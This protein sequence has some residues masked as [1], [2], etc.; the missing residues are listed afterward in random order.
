MVMILNHSQGV[1]NAQSVEF[2]TAD[3]QKIAQQY[4]GNAANWPIVLE[5]SRHDVD[6]NVLVLTEEN[7]LRLKNFSA[8]AINFQKHQK[9]VSELLKQGAEL[10][11]KKPLSKANNQIKDYKQAVKQGNYKLAAAKAQQLGESMPE[12]ETILN[13]NRRVAIQAE[14]SD[15]EGDVDKRKGL[16]GSWE[17]AQIGDYFAQSDG[18]K[19][20]ENSLA[21]L[22]FV[23]GSQIEIE[24]STV[25]V[26]RESR[27]DKLTESV[28]TDIILEDGGVLAKLSASAKN[29][30]NYNLEAGDAQT[31][32][33]STNFYA[34]SSNSQEVK[35]SNYDGEA[36]VEANDVTVTIRKNEGTV[37]QKGGQPAEP[38]KLLDAPKPVSTNTDTVIFDDSF[39]LAFTEIDEA[40][41]YR[42]EVST[43]SQFTN[44]LTVYQTTSNNLLVENLNMGTNYIHIQSID[45]FGLRGPFSKTYRV[46]RN[47]DNQPP[48]I[49]FSNIENNLIYTND[50]QVTINGVTEPEVDLSINGT[51]VP[52]EV[53]GSFSVDVSLSESE[54]EVSLKATDDSGNS[55]TKNVHIV[56]IDTGY[57]SSIEFNAT[58]ENNTITLKQDILQFSGMAYPK[59]KIMV[60]NGEIEKTIPTD[61]NGRWGGSMKPMKPQAGTLVF[62][63]IDASNNNVLFT[64][65][66]NVEIPN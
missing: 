7:R 15:K 14:L 56:Q 10:F 2:S 16:L 28:D 5:L 54:E 59:F 55:T 8:T 58:V 30:G 46:I 42:I 11:A 47:R 18:I 32:I 33:K 43:T 45:K 52:V 39:N 34:Q 49:F 37:I 35:L 6:R 31:R 17:M 25:A 12:V 48:P 60:K 24:E 44:D 65:T 64:Q 26:I 57:L 22:S 4:T 21:L 62:Q 29:K 13:A 3:V 36:M 63:F 41:F 50:N 38:I 40:R 9:R 1:V 61:N 23:D 66:Y 53:D 51:A 19:T 27:I 20:F